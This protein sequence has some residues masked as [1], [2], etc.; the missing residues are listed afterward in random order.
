MAFLLKQRRFRPILAGYTIFA[1]MGMFI[2][3]LTESFPEVDFVGDTLT[4]SGVFESIDY[5][6]DC[7]AENGNLTYKQ[8]RYSFSVTRNGPL[9]IEMLPGLQ[10]PRMLFS[11]FSLKTIEE[12]NHLNKKSSILLK[13]RI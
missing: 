4:S 12:T 8:G 13:L 2:L 11:C 5:T 1:M 9:R 7:M 6:I 3:V 10:D